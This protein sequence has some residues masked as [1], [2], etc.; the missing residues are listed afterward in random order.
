MRY[1]LC[2]T[3]LYVGVYAFIAGSPMVYIEHFHVDAQ[4]YGW[5]FAV[6]ILGVMGLSFVNRRLVTRFSLDTLLRAATFG[7][8]GAML[9]TV[10]LVAFD[11]GGLWGLVVPVFVFFSTNGIVAACATA[12]ALDGVSDRAGSAAALIG[13]L[14]YG[15]GIVSSLLLAWLSDGTARAMVGVMAAF[16]LG[17]AAMAFWRVKALPEPAE[18]QA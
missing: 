8:A 6:N 2:V 3:F 9:T 14:Q 13:S 12:A 5:L 18:S 16:A 7:A 1:T 4:H 11:I 15:S 17:A 10:F